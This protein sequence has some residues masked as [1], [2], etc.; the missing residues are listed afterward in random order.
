MRR[1]YGVRMLAAGTT[2]KR[3]PKTYGIGNV[4]EL[5]RTRPSARLHAAQLRT[6]LAAIAR[7]A[8]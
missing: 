3:V 8:R 7:F 2:A 6:V 4:P 5:D 1:Y